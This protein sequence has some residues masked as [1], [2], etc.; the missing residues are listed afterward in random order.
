[1]DNRLPFISDLTLPSEA[2]VRHKNVVTNRKREAL[3]FF[4][5]LV[6]LMLLLSRRVLLGLEHSSAEV[7]HQGLHVSIIITDCPILENIPEHEIDWQPRDPPKH[8]V[9]WCKYG[10][11]MHCTVVHKGHGLDQL[12]PF[13]F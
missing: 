3:D 8:Q 2:L 13:Q 9:K 1:M 7:T 11:L 6:R 12:W 4:I 5:V 10:G